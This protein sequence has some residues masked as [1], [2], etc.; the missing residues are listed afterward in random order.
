MI[1]VPCALTKVTNAT[2]RDD[3]TR[4]LVLQQNL[5]V[6][7]LIAR[8]CRSAQI[9]A[10]LESRVLSAAARGHHSAGPLMFGASTCMLGQSDACLRD[11]SQS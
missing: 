9:S 2:R 5:I 6:K 10:A 3:S 7:P 11:A 4:I 1:F 8:L